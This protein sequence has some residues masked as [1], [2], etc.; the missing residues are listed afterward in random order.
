MLPGFGTVSS[1]AAS[2]APAAPALEVGQWVEYRFRR[3]RERPVTVRY[4]LVERETGGDW[5]ETRYTRADGGRLLIRVL[6]EGRLDRPGRIRRVIV[7]E[8]HGQALELPAE[9]GAGALPPP[10]PTS[11]NARVLGEETVQVAGHSLRARHVRATEGPGATDAWVSTA[12][13][14]W[15]LVR[16]SSSRYE[17]DLLGFGTG[18]RTSLV[19]EAV[20]FDPSAAGR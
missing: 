9:R 11:S 7:Q 1:P 17:L 15:G 16:F 12:V 6:V 4:A 19:G 2:P 3:G 20:R 18:A 13:P 14:L 10:V 8:G 5:L